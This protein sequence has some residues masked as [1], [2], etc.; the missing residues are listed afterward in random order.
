MNIKP[1]AVYNPGLDLHLSWDFNVDP[2]SVSA[3]QVWGYGKH[4][5]AMCIKE[6]YL[7]NSNTPAT[8]REIVRVFGGQGLKHQRNIFIYGDASADKT[9]SAYDEIEEYIGTHF[10]G[11]IT[12][13]VPKSNPRHLRRLKSVNALCRNANGDVRLGIHPD[14]RFTIRDL[15]EQRMEPTGR[16]KAKNQEGDDGTTLGHCSDNVDYFIDT[17]FRYTRP[18]TQRRRSK[19]TS[20]IHR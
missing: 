8:A 10:P 17:L 18:D 12:R 3:W 16:S 1:E 6:V 5:I 11:T 20:H 7:R 13:R 4:S 9:T 15:T 2:M 19:M 14:C